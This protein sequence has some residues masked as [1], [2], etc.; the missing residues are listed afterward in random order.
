MAIKV[1]LAEEQSIL[2]EGLCQLLEE[3]KDFQVVAEVSCGSQLIRSISQFR[4]QVVL[5]NALIPHLDINEIKRIKLIN[6]EIHFIALTKP[7]TILIQNLIE[8]GIISFLAPS[9]E[10]VQLVRA[11]EITAQGRVFLHP[12]VAEQLL[13]KF[14]QLLKKLQGDEQDLK[15]VGIL[16][17]RE[18]EVLALIAQGYTNKEIAQLLFISSKTVR[19]HIGNITGKLGMKERINLALFAVRVGLIQLADSPYI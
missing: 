14:K 19:S 17:A 15:L 8:A 11:I 10:E 4:P 2:R 13:K 1:L 3:I 6:D 16:T 9:F 5:F 7:D 12:D 18:K